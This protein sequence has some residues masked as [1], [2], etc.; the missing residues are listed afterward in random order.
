MIWEHKDIRSYRSMLEG[1]LMHFDR[2]ITKF[3]TNFY[4]Q[5][6]YLW[7][8]TRSDY[9]VKFLTPKIPEEPKDSEGP[10]FSKPK[11]ERLAADI[12]EKFLE[13]ER[14]TEEIENLPK[15]HRVRCIIMDLGRFL[16]NL[17]FN[18]LNWLAQAITKAVYF[19]G[20]IFNLS[21]Y[22]FRTYNSCRY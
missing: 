6:S 16:Q 20:L 4:A 13:Y 12:K 18:W 19:I 8:E 17:I 3:F 5:W 2:E 9:I 1:G 7:S 14:I 10:K 22:L 21:F 15:M 11:I